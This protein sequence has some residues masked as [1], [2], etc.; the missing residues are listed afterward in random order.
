MDKRFDVA[1]IGGGPAGLTAA[2]YCS[3]AN[4]SA[5]IIEADTPGGKVSKTYEIANY[6]G[7]KP[8][9]GYQLAL[10]LMD[11]GTSF[12]AVMEFG[13]VESIEING[14]DK[15]VHS[16]CG[17]FTVKAVI[18]ATGTVERKLEVDRADEFIGRGISYCAVCDGAFYTGKDVVVIGGGNSALEE[19]LYLSSLVNKVY[20]VI[21]R[22][23]F[24]A[25]KGVVEKVKSN[26][27]IEIIVNS[28]ADSLIIENDEIVGLRIK[29]NISQE[30]KEISCQ[31]IFPY[32]GSKPATD[33]CRDI[34]ALNEDGYIIADSCMK[35][36]SEG[37]FA[38]GDVIVKE[39]RQVVTAT[40]DGAVAGNSAVKYLNSIS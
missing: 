31:G 35:T 1:I 26:E 33:F 4:L 39:L 28:V 12:G 32:I 37:I 20:I 16:S 14:K 38:C 29:N 11:H 23:Q 3:R 5:V 2:I 34:V 7:V 25:E 15:T 9:Y 36:S 22:D 6:P 40:G 21:R 10:D 8:T 27:K 17:D 13:T 19:A 18:I 30:I 24:R